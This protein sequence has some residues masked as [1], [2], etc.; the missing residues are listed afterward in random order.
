MYFSSIPLRDWPMGVDAWPKSP[1]HQASPEASEDNLGIFGEGDE[2]EQMAHV[3]D[4][5]KGK[6][7]TEEEPSLK[8]KSTG[9][10]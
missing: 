5:H 8:K 7:L 1:Q 4:K 3:R 9:A 6:R 2:D 10:S